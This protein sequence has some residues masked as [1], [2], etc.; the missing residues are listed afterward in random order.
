VCVDH[1][2]CTVAHAFMLLTQNKTA[3]KT[4]RHK[5]KHENK[6]APYSAIHIHKKAFEDCQ[7]FLSGFLLT[8]PKSSV[9]QV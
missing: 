5:Q 3:N 6:C 9:L 8:K 1:V 7:Y 2:M 4:Q